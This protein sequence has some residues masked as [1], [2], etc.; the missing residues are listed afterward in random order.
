MPYLG[1][2]PATNFS[3]V[4]YQDLTGG[5]GTSFTLNHP[6][7]TA[8]DIEVF[9]NN[10]RQEPG[11]AYTVAGTALTMT[12]SIAST[13][14]FYIVFQGKALQTVTP[15]A[16]TV[17]AAM[18]QSSAVTNAKIDTMAASKLTGALPAIDGSA[19][20]NISAGKVLNVVH[21]L[22]DTE[23]S[24]TGVANTVKATGLIGT[25]TPTSATSNIL[26]MYGIT[27]GTSATGAAMTG[28]HHTVYHDIGQTG[29]YTA[30]TSRYFGSRSGGNGQ[31]MMLTAGG[32]L[33]HD[34]N[35]TSA[36]NY[37][38]QFHYTSNWDKTMYVN[39]GGS[40]SPTDA[41]DGQSYITLM[42]IE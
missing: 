9:V 4:A 1:N 38:V 19:L 24:I 33:L 12:G 37:N 26:I 32:H 34:H 20:T 36:I 41:I 17:T 23:E 7:G 40:G 14:D 39:R 15:G 5:S 18:L 25:I 42:E 2:V 29:S 27:M 13:D 21:T 11:V 6:A 8:Q 30:L 31:Y 3:T 16:N 10:V 22:Y 35:T 28:Q